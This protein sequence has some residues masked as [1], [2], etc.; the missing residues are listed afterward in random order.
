MATLITV[1]TISVRFTVNGAPVTLAV[2]PG[3]ALLDVLRRE[4]GL[5]GA[6]NGCDVGICGTCSVLVNGSLKKS[7]IVTIDKIQDANIMTVEGLGAPDR[8][9]PIQDAFINNTASQ[10]GMCTPGFIMACQAYLQQKPQPTDRRHIRNFLRK[11][12]CRCTGYEQIVDAVQEAAGV[13]TAADFLRR[14]H[15]IGR[16]GLEVRPVIGHSVP[17][18]GVVAKVCGRLQYGD[19]VPEAA[20]TWHVVAVRSPHSHAR[21]VRVDAARALHSPGVARVL[22]AKDIP[23]GDN[24]VGMLVRDQRVI[25]P[26]GETIKAVGDVVAL[27]VAGTREH[28]RQAA[29]LVDVLY[30][31]LPGV[32]EAEAALQSDAPIVHPEIKDSM[33][34][35]R[36][37]LIHHQHIHKGDDIQCEADIDALFSRAAADGLTVVEGDYFAPFQDHAPLETEVAYAHWDEAMQKVAVYAPVQHVFFARRNIRDALGLSSRNVRVIGSPVGG[38]YGKR[39]DPYALTYVALASLIMKAPTKMLWTRE[40]TLQYTQKRHSYRSYYQAAVAA[41]GRI[42][43]FK[44]RVYLDG[45]AYRSWTKEVS[46]KSAVMATGPYEIPHVWIDSFGVYTNNPLCGAAR[47]FGSTG[48]LFNT[49]VF[50][51]KVA[52]ALGMDPYEFRHKNSFRKGSTTATRHYLYKGVRAV[53]CMEAAAKVHAWSKP[54]AQRREGDWLYGRGMSSIWYGNGFG[55]GIR[56]EAWPIIEIRKDG[57]VVIH[58]STVD[59]GQGSNTVFAQVTADVM[60][61]RMEDIVLHTADS[62][63]TPNCNSTVASRVTVVVGKAVEMTARALRDD[64]FAAASPILRAQPEELESLGGRIW[65]RGNPDRIILFQ[66]VTSTLTEPLMRQV[67]KLNQMFTTPLD[68]VTGEGRAYWPY[69]FATHMCTV[70]VNVRTGQVK[71]VDYTAAHDIGK[72][73]NP[74]AC[75]GQIIGGAAM[76]VGYALTEELRLEKGKVISDNFDTYALPRASDL[77][78]M[79]VIMV[80]DPELDGEL[81][82]GPNG[83]KGIG[84]PPTIAPAPAILNAVNDA[85]REVGGYITEIPL[86]PQRVKA[87]LLRQGR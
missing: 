82:F 83:A 46:T 1:P 59:Y 78:D 64:L 24:Y 30:E 73:I 21:L 48:T 44:A 36:P 18:Y 17:Q 68:P 9:A 5:T 47:G 71:L 12:F 52:R 41:D 60:G 84:E 81:D 43:A 85:L 19:D 58:A 6:K 74:Q 3:R 53:E 22:T 51:D 80:E 79:N 45:G 8:L 35:T 28:A 86:T 26:E 11:N 20:G 4:L 31:A 56:D 14:T 25:V 67:P 32:Y 34:P 10:C 57:R 62:D 33:D 40:E 70:G 63:T 23:G 2:N 66:E 61:I 27:V 50:W 75:R 39:E 49:E 15:I 16:A 29:E 13:A 37:N 55:R 76:G 38:A 69:V 54:L 7:C 77:C 72:A 65:V 87:A 42:A